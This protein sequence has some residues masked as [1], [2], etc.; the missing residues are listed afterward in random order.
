ML[1]YS[2]FGYDASIK[3]GLSVE[4]G[5]L[6]YIPF[7]ISCCL[8]P[9]QFLTPHTYKVQYVK[10]L[11]ELDSQASYPTFVL[12]TTFPTGSPSL[13]FLGHIWTMWLDHVMQINYLVFW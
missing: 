9:L 5:F 13:R 6:W 8:L 1:T 4:R 11:E 12:H 7:W 10:E 3:F 2:D